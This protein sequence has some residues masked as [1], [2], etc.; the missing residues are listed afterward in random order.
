MAE[1]DD[2]TDE[3]QKTEDPTPRRL[4]EARKR[5]QV[6]YSREI[7]NW[8]V[9]FTATVLVVMAGPGIMSD[10]K[11]VLKNV[12]EQSYAV[13][14][15]AAGLMGVMQSLFFRIG[16]DI[17]LPLI[18]LAFA[19]AVSGFLQTGP[20]FTTDPITP[21]L[22]KIS[23]IKGFSRLFSARSMV[24]LLK[25]VIKLIL[26]SVAAIMVL[27]PYFNTVEHF[28][29][30]D[31]SQT[32]FEMQSLFLKMMVA[33]LSVLFFLAILDY[34]F[35]RAEFMKNMRMSKQD[36]KEEFRQTEGDPQIKGRLR[37]LREQRARKRMMQAVPKADVVITNPT[38]YAV[39][40]KYDSGAM[41]APTMVAKGV[42]LIAERIK[43]VA[44]ENNVP[45]VENATLAR[46]LYGSMEIDQTIP[47][48][49]YKA[50]AE[51][52]SYVF[53]LRGKKV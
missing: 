37:Q 42:D 21:D 33:V 26:V 46:A 45:V 12:L 25:G 6:V 27:R 36:I 43:Q 18:F 23:L 11:D 15:D 53:K 24:E 2:S 5:G 38:H 51:V 13:P 31:F 3:T 1:E 10:I 41:D 19:G 39:A 49:H 22:S 44:K 48:D 28:V 16:G 30:L 29:G 8:M 35:Q 7:N 9:L 52:I 50:V 40:L 17:I 32:L 47:R 20:I 34:M 4:E 14:T